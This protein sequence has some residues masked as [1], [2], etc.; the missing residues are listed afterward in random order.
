VNKKFKNMKMKKYLVALFVLVMSVQSFAQVKSK[1]TTDTFTFKQG[2]TL[3]HWTSRPIQGWVYGDPAWFSKKDVEWI[4]ATGIDHIQLYVSG[5]EISNP[6]NTINYQKLS[7]VDSAI[8]WCKEAKTG[9]V[10]TITQFPDFAVDTTLAKE[11][12]AE[13]ILNKQAAFWGL[14]ADYFK[15]NGNNVRFLISHNAQGDN[16]YRNSYNLRALSEIRKTNPTR[17]VYLTASSVN[18]LADLKTPA[19]D[20]NICI[21]ARMALAPNVESEALDVFLWQ[22]VFEKKLPPITFP[23]TLPALDNLVGESDKW[24]IGYSNIKL[25][26]AYLDAKFQKVNR[27]M[28][29][30]HPNREFYISHWRY[31]TGYPFDPATVK[32]ETSIRNFGQAFSKTTKKYQI[33]WSIYDYNSGSCIRYP[34]GDKA[35]ILEALRLNK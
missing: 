19:N 4:A 33:N 26:E 20:K 12:Q 23:G 8:A 1:K 35:L 28:K 25:D 11:D 17:K 31:V 34:N 6:D 14:V 27:W 10:L 13:I 7:V 21:A 24:A 16:D 32:D 5:R 22:H 30:N 3:N 15:A 29:E 18:R 2:V 9:I